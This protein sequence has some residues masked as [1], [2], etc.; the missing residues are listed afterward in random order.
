MRRALQ[1]SF[2]VLL[3]CGAAAGAAAVAFASSTDGTIDV[4][5]KYA[6]G[7]TLGWL[8]FGT[9]GGNVHVTDAALTGYVWS[10]NFGWIHLNPSKSGVLNDG[11]GHLSGDGWGTNTGYV[12]FSGVTINSSGKFTGTAVG[13]VAGNIS[14]DCPG[15]NVVTDWRPQSSRGGGGGGGGT[16]GGGIVSAG[17]GGTGYPGLGPLPGAPAACVRTADFNHDGRVDIIDL[18][19]LLYYY[20][21]SGPSICPYDLNGNGTVD[22]PDISILMYYWNR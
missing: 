13:S 10:E 2:I 19:I 9:S 6:W 4:N 21:R 22:F 8:N 3:C 14:F 7:D 12:S 15:C 16:G 1:R 20:G 5:Q 11:N 17:G 18:S